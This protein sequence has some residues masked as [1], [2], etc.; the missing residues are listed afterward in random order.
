MKPGLLRYFVQSAVIM[1]V[2]ISCAL[3][4]TNT[5]DAES[6]PVR[7]LSH[8]S[9]EVRRPGFLFKLKQ[10]IQHPGPVDGITDSKV[11]GFPDNQVQLA[12]K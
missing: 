4:K 6:G 7:V 11:E 3:R 8:G 12:V 10:G 5:S 1:A 9:G 2:A